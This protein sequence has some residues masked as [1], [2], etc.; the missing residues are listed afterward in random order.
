[1]RRPCSPDAFLFS[2]IESE[3]WR[4]DRRAVHFN[5]DRKTKV[6]PSELRARVRLKQARKLKVSKRPKRERYDS[7]SYRRAV[8][9]GIQKARKAGVEIPSWH[10]HRL[11][12]SCGTEI[13]KRYGIEA[14]QVILGHTTANVTEIYA[15]RNLKLAVNVA[16]EMG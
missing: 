9:Y 10:P 7:D 1:M 12:H 3:T 6:Y 16:M 13:R 2:P 5:P 14:A 4:N 8:T 15:E 11:R